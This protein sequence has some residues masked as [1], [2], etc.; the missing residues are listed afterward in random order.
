MLFVTSMNLQL[1]VGNCKRKINHKN[2][3]NGE[4][5]NCTKKLQPILFESGNVEL[6]VS[7]SL[8]AINFALNKPIG[9]FKS[10]KPRRNGK[11]LGKCEYVNQTNALLQLN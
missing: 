5:N 10:C 6:L 1:L 3:E 2:T 7:Y 4:T 8:I 11:L 9:K